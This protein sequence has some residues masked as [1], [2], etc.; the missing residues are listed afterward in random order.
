[1]SKKKPKPVPDVS[2]YEF[3]DL[4]HIPEIDRSIAMTL[5][6]AKKGPLAGIIEAH[7]KK[8]KNR[9][10]IRVTGLDMEEVPDRIKQVIQEAAGA[11][12]IEALKDIFKKAGFKTTVQTRVEAESARTF[13]P[14]YNFQLSPFADGDWGLTSLSP[15][16]PA[17]EP[18]FM[19]MPQDA[20]DFMKEF[21]VDPGKV[22]VYESAYSEMS[23]R[24]MS[25]N[26]T[27]HTENHI[28]GTVTL[29]IQQWQDRITGKKEAA[30]DELMADPELVYNLFM[31]RL[32]SDPSFSDEFIDAFLD[33]KLPELATPSA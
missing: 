21:P 16:P 12:S 23:H 33:R 22:H 19:V 5:E 3:I 2:I 11:E 32:H 9:P 13:P 17:Y 7:G 24:H 18:Y 6:G 15:W 14:L 28:S 27:R 20:I 26:F 25:L 8:E 4:V 31:Y 10:A 30:E 29:N 1:M